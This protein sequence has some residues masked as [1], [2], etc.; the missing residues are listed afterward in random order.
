VSSQL[1]FE[2]AFEFGDDGIL[3]SYWEARWPIRKLLEMY[4]R[5][6][7]FFS[8][9]YLNDPFG[10]Q[11]NALLS[12]WLHFYLPEDLEVARNEGR[13]ITT[14]IAIDTGSGGTGKDPDYSAGTKLERIGDR[15]FFTEK[16]N[17]RQPLE[18]QAQYIEDWITRVRGA[19][20]LWVEDISTQGYVW[21]D[22]QHVNKGAGSRHAIQIWQPPKKMDKMTRYLSVAPR[23]EAAQIL[24]PGMLAGGKVVVHPD[25]QDF[26]SEWG[27]VPTGHD[28]ILDT[29]YVNVF[30]QF[31]DTEVV[32]FIID[33][34]RGV[35]EQHKGDRC[36]SN[37]HAMFGRPIGECTRCTMNLAMSWANDR[38]VNEEQVDSIGAPLVGLF[39]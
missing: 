21:K 11:G 32:G 4:E 16:F 23:F 7:V 13:A 36:E 31:G 39:H 20:L 8:V 28:D 12:E 5:N 9:S 29:A 6:P 37:A 25:W 30:K 35:Q 17:T 3:E 2:R 38:M 14:S 15:G 19:D 10:L 34:I 1:I 26:A 22:F 33:V 24:L 27:A 18:L